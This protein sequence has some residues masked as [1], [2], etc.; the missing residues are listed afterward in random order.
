MPRLSRADLPDGRSIHCT[1]RDE[2]RGVIGQIELY[3]RHDISI[4]AG[5]CVL[6]VGANIGLFALEASRRGAHVHAFEPMPA[7]FAALDTNARLYDGQIR[8]H[9]LAL[10]AVAGIETF[11]YFRWMSSLSTR[12][13]EWIAKNAA[14]GVAAVLDDVELAP[15]FG[16]FR[17]S[18][19]WLRRVLVNG[20]VKT[21]LRPRPVSCRVET[22][23]RVIHALG[24]DKIDLLKIDVEGAEW[25]VL[26]GIHSND[27]PRI[28][29]VVAEVHDED[30]RV[31]RVENLL[32]DHGF[33][34]V[35][36]PEPQSAAWG[37]WLVWARRI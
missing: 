11:A 22:L 25:E 13:P 2:V 26:R 18:P 29:Q 36:E 28:R 20:L 4:K 8:A 7:T 37:I 32:R 35:S 5:D 1:R 9:N 6:D 21:I 16:W 19:D 15:R 10:G 24:I 23:S 14:S 34:V 3:L 17:H 30:G 27:W 12:F 31:T 33:H